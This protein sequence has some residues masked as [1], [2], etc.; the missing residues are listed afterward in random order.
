LQRCEC[1][2]L[3]APIRI[4]YL[5]FHHQSGEWKTDYEH[6]LEKPYSS[7]KGFKIAGF[8]GS[9]FKVSIL[10]AED[11]YVCLD[12]LVEKPVQLNFLCVMH[13]LVIHCDDKLCTD[14]HWPGTSRFCS[15]LIMI[16]NRPP[17]EMNVDA[18]DVIDVSLYRCY[19]YTVLIGDNRCRIFWAFLIVGGLR[20]NY[21]RFAI[22]WIL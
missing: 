16:H 6:L 20:L 21:R 19:T 11:V 12:L 2:P 1:F 3:G 18:D 8:I 13:T 22:L 5:L 17:G 9:L 7:I 14:E 15:R 4:A 10:N